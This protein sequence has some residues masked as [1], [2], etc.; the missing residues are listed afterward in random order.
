MK[1]YTLAR[2]YAKAAYLFATESGKVA[3][4]CDF[5]EKMAELLADES[6]T[7]LLKH[8][9][10]KLET[11]IELTIDRLGIEDT[12]HF[13]NFLLLLHE[14]HRLSLLAEIYELFLADLK[15][16]I[17]CREVVVK[18]AFSLSKAE[19]NTLEADLAVHFK[20]AVNITVVE[21]AS[22][23]GG[24]M[25]ESGDYVRDASLAGQ[26]QRLKQNLTL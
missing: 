19:I 3:A 8:P 12:A 21:D 11:F 25:I 7:P 2:P 15:K 17:D 13:R 24:I 10:F 16:D 4:W 20:Q 23:I 26:L 18:S 14:N 9:S 1:H 6:F 5:L 22:L